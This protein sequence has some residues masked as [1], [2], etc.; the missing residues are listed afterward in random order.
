MKELIWYP[1]I[2]SQVILHEKDEDYPFGQ[3]AQ[4]KEI[5]DKK[6]QPSINVESFSGDGEERM[7]KFSE[8][9]E[10]LFRARWWSQ[11]FYRLSREIMNCTSS[12]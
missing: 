9:Q 10:I 4:K 5:N 1:K 2:K 7:G 8:R 11:N 3:Y 12:R 6:N